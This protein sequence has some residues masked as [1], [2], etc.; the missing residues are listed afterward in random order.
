MTK[1]QDTENIAAKT[2]RQLQRLVM[3]AVT[4]GVGPVTGSIAYAHSRL[5]ATAEDSLG[6]DGGNGG[7]I[8]IGAGYAHAGSEDSEAAIRRIR[9]IHLTGPG[10]R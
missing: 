2:G 10:P 9:G 6:G 4:D 3:T 1:F 7:D 8:H 5:P